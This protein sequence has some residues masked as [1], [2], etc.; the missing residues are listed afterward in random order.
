MKFSEEETSEESSFYEETNFIE[1][2]KKEKQF[3]ENY[4]INN[5]AYIPEKYPKYKS[6]YISILNK[7]NLNSPKMLLCD[8]NKFKS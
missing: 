2:L 4:F 8:N 6:K 5:Y 3:W 1:E 7:I